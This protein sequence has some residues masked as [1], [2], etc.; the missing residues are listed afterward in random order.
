MFIQSLI[1]Y[2]DLNKDELPP[3]GWMKSKIHYAIDL[4]CSGNLVG[5]TSME[6]EDVPASIIIPYQ[7]TRTSGKFA[8]FLSD[9]AKYLL[10]VPSDFDSQ[11]KTVVDKEGKTSKEAKD[12]FT[13]SRNL[14]LALL[15]QCKC[16]EAIALC[17]FFTNWNPDNVYDDDNILRCSSDISTAQLVF[18]VAG[19]QVTNTN[20]IISVYTSYFKEHLSKGKTVGTSLISGD[21][22]PI[23]EVHGKIKNIRGSGSFGCT[24]VCSNSSAFNSYGKEQAMNAQL[25]EEENLIAC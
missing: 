7:E 16:E 23:A 17:S 13:L 19:R 1:K 14:H 20:E 18:R 2:A 10:G 21:S 9:N 8:Y 5:I 6:R 3:F 25:T 12:C 24:L 15:D 4:D 11:I 22:G